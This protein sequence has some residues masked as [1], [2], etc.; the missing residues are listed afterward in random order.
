M[1][2]QS[3]F[4]LRHWIPD[5]R[6]LKAEYVPCPLSFQDVKAPRFVRTVTMTTFSSFLVRSRSIKYSMAVILSNT[7]SVEKMY[8][9]KHEINDNQLLSN[10]LPY[11]LQ[12]YI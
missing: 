10:M 7:F 2:E 6:P 9:V 1:R 4:V 12:I 5:I 11:I 8:D 3:L